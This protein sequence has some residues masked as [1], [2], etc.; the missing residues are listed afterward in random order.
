LNHFERET[1][2]GLAPD[3]AACAWSFPHSAR[4]LEGVWA[5]D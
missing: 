5:E 1:R 2:D 3:L 4:R